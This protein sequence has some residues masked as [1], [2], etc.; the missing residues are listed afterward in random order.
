VLEEGNREGWFD[1]VTIM[2]LAALAVVSLVTFVVHEL[3]TPNPVVDFRVFKN[4]SYSAATG[5]NFLVGTALF[6][7]GFM[8]SLYLGAIMHYQ[9]LD[10]GVLFLKGSCIQVLLMP[11]IGKLGG[12]FDGRKLVAYG[13]AMQVLS[14]WLNGHFSTSAD[15]T[16]LMSPIFVRALGLG[17]IFVPLSVIALSDLPFEL[18]G[19]ATGLFNLT[20]ELGGSIGTAYMSTMISHRSAEAYAHLTENVT[21]L[22]PLAQSQLSGTA[23]G[24]G[25]RFTDPQ[26]GALTLMQY[27]ISQQALVRAFNQNYMELALV[28]ALSLFL[29]LL[30][31]RPRPGAAPQGA[32]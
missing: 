17:F 20:R 25:W 32:H 26:A 31:K 5:I 30:L 8:L 11:M 29:V 16:T 7:G 14:L 27:R 6:S 2:G 4:R 9:A 1:S 12:K 28:F 24:L 22:S 21:R 18:R 15:S 13:V 3:E 10:I 23:Q 19:G